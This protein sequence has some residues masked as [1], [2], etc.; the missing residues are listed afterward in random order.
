MQD[1]SE[2]GWIEQVHRIPEHI[3]IE[4]SIT[5][6]GGRAIVEQLV[7]SVVD[8]GGMTRFTK[9]SSF[10]GGWWGFIS[11][12]RYDRLKDALVAWV[13]FDRGCQPY[14]VD[15]LRIACNRSKRDRHILYSRLRRPLLSVS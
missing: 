15:H 12:R 4:V 7:L 3:S 1:N 8:V 14:G 9:L 2:S 11:P 10:L 13:A 5:V 6:V